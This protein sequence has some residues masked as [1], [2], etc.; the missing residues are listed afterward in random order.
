MN[1]VLLNE[2]RQ[3]QNKIDSVCRKQGRAMAARA[4]NECCPVEIDRSMHILAQL[5]VNSAAFRMVDETR[6]AVKQMNRAVVRLI[7]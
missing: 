2:P 3:I 4:V 6:H 7:K 1:E 5:E